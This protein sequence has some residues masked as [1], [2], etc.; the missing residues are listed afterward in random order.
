MLLVA[1][2]AERRVGTALG[3][4][5]AVG[6][7][8]VLIDHFLVTAGALGLLHGLT[9]PQL[10]RRPAGMALNARH[11]GMTRTG[12]AGHRGLIDEKRDGL[13]IARRLEL[14]VGMT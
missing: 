11:A 2:N 14:G 13:A 4:E 12:L 8:L 3:G 9:G 1:V 6:A 7:F 10:G 5:L